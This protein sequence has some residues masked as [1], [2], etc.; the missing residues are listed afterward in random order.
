MYRNSYVE[1][2][3]DKLKFNARKFQEK[4]KKEIIG[5]VKANGYCTVDYMEVNALEECGIDFF[6]VS[7]LD[8]AVRLRMHGICGQ[9]LILGYVPDDAMNLIK[10][11]DISIVT[12]SKE[13]VQKADLEGVK[14]HLKLNT[15]M[16]RIGV[17]VSEAEEVLAMLIEKKAVVEGVMSHFSSADCDEEYSKNAYYLLTMILNTSTCPQQMPQS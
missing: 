7:S 5:V 8:E 2:D 6:A 4:S 10:E 11:N 1:V 16:N 17:N 9:I 13:F 14:V 15:G 3:L 12:L